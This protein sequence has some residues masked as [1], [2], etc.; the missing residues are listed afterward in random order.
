MSLRGLYRHLLLLALE[1]HGVSVWRE[2]RQ[3]QFLTMLLFRHRYNRII[4][5]IWQAAN[6]SGGLCYMQVTSNGDE[7]LGC[8][9]ARCIHLLSTPS[10]HH[11][12]PHPAPLP[13]LQPLLHSQLQLLPYNP[14]LP[15]H[16]GRPVSGLKS[17]LVNC[18]QNKLFS[19]YL[20]L[21]MMEVK[22]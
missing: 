13:D 21:I 15:T 18:Y 19:V 20:I 11:S 10:H 2:V 14:L 8:W 5:I 9:F 7:Q 3:S 6:T 16:T 22:G 17:K 1:D 4:R 12:P